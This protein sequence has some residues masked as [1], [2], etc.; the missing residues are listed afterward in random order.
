MKKCNTCEN[1]KKWGSEVNHWHKHYNYGVCEKYGEYKTDLTPCIDMYVDCK[2]WCID[3]SIQ[4]DNGFC[5]RYNYDCEKCFSKKFWEELTD[6]KEIDNHFVNSESY[7]EYPNIYQVYYISPEG[8]EGGFYNAKFNVELDDG[9]VLE[10]VGL[11]GNGFAPNKE[12]VSKL[13][14]GTFIKD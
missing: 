13:K 3:E 12:I 10:N 2:R 1:F 6:E 4:L 14:K 11:W 5:E 7:M 9:T 8:K